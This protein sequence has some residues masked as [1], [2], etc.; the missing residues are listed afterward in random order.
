MGKNH[1]GR[2]HSKLAE[3]EEALKMLA[4]T[5]RE[6]KEDLTVKVTDDIVDDDQ[7]LI[8]MLNTCKG[9]L[10]GDWSTEVHGHAA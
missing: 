3:A 7:I 4:N 8:V 10:A 2:L 9:R 5:K 6:L 1:L